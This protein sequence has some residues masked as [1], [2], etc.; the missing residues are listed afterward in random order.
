ML[1]E[2]AYTI[3]DSIK[4]FK[5]LINGEYVGLKKLLWIRREQENECNLMVFLTFS[6]IK[7]LEI[8]VPF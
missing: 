4:F 7:S 6:F 2:C 1:P 3:D 5:M 8:D